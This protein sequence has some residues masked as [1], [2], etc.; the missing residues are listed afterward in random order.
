MIIE[1]KNL[2][3][4]KQIN[5]TEF[6]P[7]NL[8]D[9]QEIIISSKENIF[10]Q[11]KMYLHFIDSMEIYSENTPIYSSKVN[12]NEFLFQSKIIPEKQIKII[13]KPLDYCGRIQI[14][15]LFKS[16]YLDKN[17]VHIT[18]D[19]I[20]IINL[21][22]RPE[23]KAHMEKQLELSGL[24]NY[25]FVEAI[26]GTD[27]KIQS[28]YK[29]IKL[30]T[31][32]PIITSGHF[33]C[34]LSHIKAIKTALERNYSNVMILEDDINFIEGFVNKIKQIKVPGDFNMIY[35]GGLI[36]KKKIFLNSWAKT[37]KIMGAYAYIL[38]KSLYKVLLD[39]LEKKLDYVDV[40]Y[41]KYIQSQT[42]YNVY[43][44]DDLVKT[45][46]DSTDTSSKTKKLVK[47]LKL[48]NE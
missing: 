27:K 22:K 5:Y 28:I 47:M 4:I 1:H 32:C 42:K 14:K 8:K 20:L 35:L 18:W 40:Y 13:F 30:T 3:K 21:A 37:D 38:N 16:E 6:K 33:A 25:E 36:Y 19:R 41:T 7:T 24:T 39:D 34:L 29:K 43:L 17:L 31:S 11:F 15:N 9:N 45:T 10:V 46:I 12:F 23:R 44:L 2:K 48:S 26:D